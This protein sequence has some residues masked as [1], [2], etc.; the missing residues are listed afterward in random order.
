MGLGV[1]SLGMAK[2][3]T[4][5]FSEKEMQGWRSIGHIIGKNESFGNLWGS[6]GGAT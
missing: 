6:S 4:G 3:P 5:Q 1:I 2:A